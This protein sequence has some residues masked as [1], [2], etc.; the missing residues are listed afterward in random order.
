MAQNTATM[1]VWDGLRWA[2]VTPQ[3]D[4]HLFLD[5]TR[6]TKSAMF[7]RPNVLTARSSAE[8]M[9]LIA[10]KGLPQTMSLDHDLGGDDT[11]FKFL[12]ELINGHLDEK[13]DLRSITYVQ[14]HS[15]NPV[16]AKKIFD[17]WN[18]FAE[19]C[20]VLANSG[21]PRA[22]RLVPAQGDKDG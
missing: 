19:Q 6:W 2:A 14:V 17:L 21:K 20:G 7:V 10:E 11:G 13:W 18:S 15:R 22:A 9:A 12:W 5:D 3:V 16:G 4:W 8:A 1:Y